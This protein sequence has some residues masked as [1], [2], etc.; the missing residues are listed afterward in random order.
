MATDNEDFMK[1]PILLSVLACSFAFAS[2]QTFNLKELHQEYLQSRSIGHG[3]AVE[4]KELF[5]KVTLTFD[6]GPHPTYTRKI[7]KILKTYSDKLE[8]Q[9]KERIKATFF[10]NGKQVANYKYHQTNKY[11]YE[12]VDTKASRMEI[13][14][15][16]VDQ[17]HILAN[18]SVSHASLTATF[19]NTSPSI[20]QNEIKL[21]HDAVDFMMPD[22][23]ECQNKW[24]F[25]APYGGWR[26]QNA[27]DGNAE[28]KTVEKYVGPIFW[29][30]G[31]RVTYYGNSSIPSDAADWECGSLGKSA[32]FCARGY[33]NR[34]FRKTSNQKKIRGGIVLMHDVQSIT[35]KLLTYSLRVWTGINPFEGGTK[36]YKDLEKFV[37]D[38][39]FDKVP[40]ME[41]VGLDSIKAFDKFDERF[42]SGY[43]Q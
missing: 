24:F 41:V 8:A 36:K 28:T 15:E 21:T 38:Y 17:G 14:Q 4:D 42:T 33:L 35:P 25:R 29:D 13:V 5:G 39:K 23:R 26:S 6:D 43:C 34:T 9:G 22:I 11:A 16:I 37:V 1:K 3:L 27:T 7:L 40:T 31:G 30:I 19:L 12:L 18:H 32:E 10:I 2:N 20:L